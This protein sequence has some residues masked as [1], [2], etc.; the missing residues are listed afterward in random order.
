MQA[1]F[2][3][4]ALMSAILRVMHP[5]LYESG[6][7]TVKKL[8]QY[9]ELHPALE[10]WPSVF[11]AVTALSNRETPF[12]RDNYSRAQWYD[13]LTTI[14]PYQDAVMEFPGLGMKLRYNSGTVVGFSGKI[15]R[16][17][18]GDCK[19]DRVCLAYYMRDKVHER[20]GIEAAQWM[21]E[22]YYLM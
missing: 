13:L 17:G 11:N 18:V 15:V 16:H 7:A 22:A 4:S 2:E 21:K 3:T 10:Y 14:G 1:M 20:M 12:H 9:P 6:R 8:W 5:A 19:G